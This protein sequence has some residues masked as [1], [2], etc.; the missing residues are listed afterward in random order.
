LVVAPAV[1][2]KLAEVA[3]AGTV[4]EGGMLSAVEEV[5]VSVMS[6]PAAGAPDERLTVQFVLWFGARLV[7]AHCSPV[8][9]TGVVAT[10]VLVIVPAAADS[11]MPLPPTLAPTLPPSPTGIDPLAAETVAETVA[12]TPSSIVLLLSPA[13]MHVYALGVPAQVRDFP[14]ARADGPATTLKFVRFPDG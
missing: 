2:V 11:T 8:S 14:A 5:P 13:A 7:A 6:V 10:P 1:V 12:T 9:A 3:A 4:T